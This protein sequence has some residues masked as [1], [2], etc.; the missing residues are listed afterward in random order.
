MTKKLSGLYAITNENLMPE[1]HF[2]SMAEAAIS[3]GISI[4]QYRDKST[5][6]N[7][8]QRQA[9]A[10]KKLCDKHNVFFIINDDINLVTQVDADGIHIGINDCS[11]EETRDLIGTDKIIGVSCYNRMDLAI[12]AINK[13]ANYIAFGSFFGSSIKPDAPRASSELISTFK[14]QSSLPVCCIGGITIENHQ[15]LLDA[16]TDMLAVISDIFAQRNDEEISR[17]CAQYKNLF[18][19]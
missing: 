10:L 13:G 5:D 7:K 6:K 16:G 3:S 17:K 8:R 1:K 18:N 12:D 4:L 11:I 19:T 2:L 15:P 9:S 14:H